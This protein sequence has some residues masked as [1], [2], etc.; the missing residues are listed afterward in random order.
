MAVLVYLV[1]LSITGVVGESVTPFGPVHA[2]LTFTGT[3]T[4]GLN[5]TVQVR[6]ISDPTGRMGLTRLLMA[7]T[8]VV[9]GTVWIIV[10]LAWMMYTSM[11]N[12]A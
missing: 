5:S 3:F 10:Q 12:F 2:V 4:A 1:R 6:V 9:A 8:K 11:T 7:V